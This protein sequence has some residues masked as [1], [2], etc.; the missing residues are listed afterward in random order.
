MPRPDSSHIQQSDCR[1]SHLVCTLLVS[2]DRGIA[3]EGTAYPAVEP[4]T[5]DIID[6]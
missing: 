5:G 4:F 6:F 2:E 1:A 3:E